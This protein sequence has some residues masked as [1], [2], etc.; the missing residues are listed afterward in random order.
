MDR[1]LECES[2]IEELGGGVK[3][4]LMSLYLKKSA[5]GRGLTLR[6]WVLD[7]EGGRKPMQDD[8]NILA[9]LTHAIS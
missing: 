4:V 9:Y 2:L 1:G 8:S 6:E 5:P 7:D 3:S